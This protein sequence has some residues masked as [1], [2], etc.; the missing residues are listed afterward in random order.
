MGSRRFILWIL[1][2]RKNHNSESIKV[3]SQRDSRTKDLLCV[4]KYRSSFIE[5]IV[6]TKFDATFYDPA[7]RA[8]VMINSIVKKEGVV[9]LKRMTQ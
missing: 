8:V 6:Y 5:K 4:R 2:Y 1:V 9:K 3:N 7:Q